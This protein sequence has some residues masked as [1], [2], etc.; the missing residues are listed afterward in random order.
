MGLLEFALSDKRPRVS[1]FRPS[2]GALCCLAVV[3]VIV[4]IIVLVAKRRR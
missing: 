3:V 4:A 1:V 2:F